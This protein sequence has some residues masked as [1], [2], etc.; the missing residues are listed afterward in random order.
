[1]TVEWPWAR[2]DAKEALQGLADADWAARKAADEGLAAPDYYLVIGNAIN[3]LGD[4]AD[5]PRQVVGKTL[6]DAEEAA[7]IGG[8]FEAFEIVVAQVSA[9]GGRVAPDSAFYGASGWSAVRDAASR[10]L[11]RMNRADA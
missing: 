6:R 7:L 2:Q 11:Q 1:M 8:V 3:V 10:A 5:P 4:V 9:Q